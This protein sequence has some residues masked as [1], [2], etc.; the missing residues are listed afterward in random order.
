MA[1]YYKDFKKFDVLIVKSLSLLF[2]I[3][4]CL[5][6]DFSNIMFEIDSL[7]LTKLL[8]GEIVPKGLYAKFSYRF[9]N[10][11]TKCKGQYLMYTERGIK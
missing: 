3:Q 4:L 9:V 8:K 1:A 6:K 10:I 7:V 2:A 5:R 11:F